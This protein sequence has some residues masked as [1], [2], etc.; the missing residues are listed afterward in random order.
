MNNCWKIGHF[1]VVSLFLWPIVYHSFYTFYLGSFYVCWVIFYAGS[2][3]LWCSALGNAL[4]RVILRC[5]AFN[6]QSFFVSSFYFQSFCVRSFYVYVLGKSF[7]WI[8]LTYFNILLHN[9]HSVYSLYLLNFDYWMYNYCLNAFSIVYS[10][11]G[12][13][14]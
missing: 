10:W 13:L 4:R 7:Y 8:I 1:F 9:H 2:F 12:Q 6:V 5:I 11:T 3:L 14:G